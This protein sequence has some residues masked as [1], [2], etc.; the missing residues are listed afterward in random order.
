MRRES[1]R[2][3]TLLL[4]EK[5]CRKNPPI[6]I[7]SCS[8]VL[9]SMRLI[10][11]HRTLAMAVALFFPLILSSAASEPRL[12]VY[13]SQTSYSLPVLDREGKAYIAVNELL[14]PL[15]AEPLQAK[16]KEWRIELNKADARFTEGTQKAVIRGSQVDLEG[17]VLV[18]QQRVL[19]PLN[20][21]LPLLSRLLHASVDYHQP[22]RRI[23]VGNALAHFSASFNGGSPPALVLNFSQPVHPDG[24][25][26]EEHGALFT[27][28]NRTTLIFKKE[29]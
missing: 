2:C 21:A 3:V 8:A 10:S 23:F 17:K 4:P 19:V 5:C 15:G 6:S 25:R 12:T 16:G 13:T 26:S 9:P 11:G 1:S 27:H 22:A 7:P 18:E 20:A 29:P 14:A 28:T 24:E